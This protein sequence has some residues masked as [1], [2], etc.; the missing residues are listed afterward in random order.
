MEQLLTLKEQVSHDCDP[1]KAFWATNGIVI[2]NM[3]DLL[4]T[5]DAMDEYAFRY[6]VNEDHNK[7]DFADWVR[8]VMGDEDLAMKLESVLDKKKYIQIIKKRL[9]Q[10]NKAK[11]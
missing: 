5:I 9:T 2:R 11:N 8:D 6:H 1:G 4:S 7:N 3:R 10:L